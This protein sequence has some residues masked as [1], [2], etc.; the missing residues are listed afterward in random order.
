M[1]LLPYFASIPPPTQGGKFSFSW[2]EGE[3]Y[4][5]VGE[6]PIEISIFFEIWGVLTLGLVELTLFYTS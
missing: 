2:M 4:Q 1:H 3:N 5:V 6:I